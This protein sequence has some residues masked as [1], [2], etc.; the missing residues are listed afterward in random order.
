MG[1][2]RHDGVSRGPQREATAQGRVGGIALRHVA[3]I[4]SDIH[5]FRRTR[6]LSR[7]RSVHAQP[8]GPGPAAAASTVHRPPRERRPSQ[9]NVL[10]PSPRRV[11]PSWS[12]PGVSSRRRPRALP[13]ERS[14]CGMTIAT[15]LLALL[16]A[17]NPSSG[18]GSPTRLARL[19]RRLVRPVP[20]ER[21][22]VDQLSRK[23]YPVKSINI[24]DRRPRPSA[25]GVQAVRR[26]SSWIA[27][28]GARP[29][30]R[31]PARR[32]LDASTWP[33]GPRPSP[34]P[35]QCPGRPPRRCAG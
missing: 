5:F 32:R 2:D 4:P 16:T 10:R 18:G 19:P 35:A 12:S 3:I 22:A 28:A 25:Y 23:G 8:A 26:L 27:R 17:T 15:L 30:Q 6:P 33:P 13:R 24:D 14:P 21:P 34:R 20:E 1:R 9:R 31:A 11:L 29:H 7:T